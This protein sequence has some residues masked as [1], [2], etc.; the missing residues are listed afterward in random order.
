MHRATSVARSSLPDRP[1]SDYQNRPKDKTFRWICPR[2]KIQQRST[3]TSAV[4]GDLALRQSPDNR[5]MRLLRS[6]DQ[7][8]AVPAFAGVRSPKNHSLAAWVFVFQPFAP[9]P[10]LP[11]QQ[12]DSVF[13]APGS[14]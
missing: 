5:K 4:L 14:E 9:S 13:L 8:G 6:P 11:Y 7:S 12:A 2:S 1:R 10:A 3:T